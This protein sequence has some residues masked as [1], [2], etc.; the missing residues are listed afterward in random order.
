MV[1]VDKVI[2]YLLLLLRPCVVLLKHLKV[3]FCQFSW[4]SLVMRYV[5]I[6]LHHDFFTFHSLDLHIFT[7]KLLLGLT[8]YR[9]VRVARLEIPLEL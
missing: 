9:K 4:D 2:L 8:Y 5:L 7:Q 3:I 1:E 6:D